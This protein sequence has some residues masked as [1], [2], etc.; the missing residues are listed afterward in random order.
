MEDDSTFQSVN[1]PT[2]R[3]EI[4]ITSTPNNGTK[5]KQEP[6]PVET[7]AGSRRKV[8]KSK[9]KKANS[10]TRSLSTTTTSENTS[11]ELE[12]TELE[13]LENRIFLRKGIVRS[14]RVAFEQQ[15]LP[16]EQRKTQRRNRSSNNTLD[17]ISENMSQ[18]QSSTSQPLASNN[19]QQVTLA[20]IPPT[21]NNSP[22]APAFD[23]SNMKMM[24]EEV[25]EKMLL[26]HLDPLKGTIN[27]SVSDI[28]NELETV[29]IKIDRNEAER[30]V[31]QM[32]TNE[33]IKLLKMEMKEITSTLNTQLDRIEVNAR[34]IQDVNYKFDSV[35]DRVENLEAHTQVK[36]NR[37]NRQND[38]LFSKICKT[39]IID[40]EKRIKIKNHNVNMN[41]TNIKEIDKQLQAE[42]QKLCKTSSRYQIKDCQMKYVRSTNTKFPITEY[43]VPNKDIRNFLLTLNQ[44]IQQRAT[45]TMQILEV[46]PD[47]Y[48]D[49][50]KDLVA[51]GG[52]FKKRDSQHNQTNTKQFRVQYENDCIV[53]RIR[54]G[55]GN[56]LLHP[57]EKPWR[58]PMDWYDF[59]RNEWKRRE[60]LPDPDE[61]ERIRKEVEET[62]K[63]LY[64]R[65]I[66]DA[67]GSIVND[68]AAVTNAMKNK[69]YN[70]SKGKISTNRIAGFLQIDFE[71]KEEAM[72][73]YRTHNNATI[74][75]RMYEIQF[76]SQTSRVEN[77]TTM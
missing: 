44:N 6:S 34:A 12:D 1:E 75:G 45:N 7:V 74:D 15:T 65:I 51:L 63:T 56:F 71:S 37:V 11:I 26:Q 55:R 61:E 5:R 22:T 59:D 58:P 73:A 28:A 43:E 19:Q 50:H 40:A 20:T 21:I 23:G 60:R 29:S 38:E 24:M 13:E 54:N 46:I 52:C 3:Q 53:L 33:E 64:I 36:I 70:L 25:M 2:D 4:L 8:R 31:A 49:K 16:K 62:E 67:Q 68:T 9:R 69:S 27:Q 41:N 76:A 30:K 66:P 47:P 48:F 35:I 14:T 10:Q 72:E 57:T 18:S 42:L 77:I 32:E 17:S 39:T